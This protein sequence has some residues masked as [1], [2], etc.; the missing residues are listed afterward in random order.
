MRNIIA[1]EAEAEY[2]TIFVS[3][4]TDVPIRTT[5]TEMGLIQGPTA[6]QVD[7][8]TGSGYHN[9]GVSPK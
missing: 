9:K 3:A 6:I 1:S 8:S 2:G 5:L 7:N 4:Q